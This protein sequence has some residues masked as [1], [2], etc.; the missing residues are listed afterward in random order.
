MTYTLSLTGGG[1]CLNELSFIK[2][3]NPGS[4]IYRGFIFEVLGRYCNTSRLLCRTVY[5]TLF[6]FIGRGVEG[7]LFQ[8]N[9][10]DFGCILEC[11]LI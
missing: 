1:G 5:I 10:K 11:I 4:N 6:S 3:K 7:M 8:E 9:V 2:G